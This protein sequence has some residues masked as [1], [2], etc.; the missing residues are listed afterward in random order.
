MCRSRSRR[1]C[2]APSAHWVAWADAQSYPRPVGLC[3]QSHGHRE[4]SMEDAYEPPFTAA[5]HT[6]LVRAVL[7]RPLH[8]I[9]YLNVPRG[10]S[11][12]T[13]Q[14]IDA[15]LQ[16]KSFDSGTKARLQEARTACLR[17][18]EE[19]A[20]D[21]AAYTERGDRLQAALEGKSIPEMIAAVDDLLA[22]EQLDDRSRG[23]L[24]LAKAILEDGAD[25]IYSLDFPV[26][27]LVDDGGPSGP[28]GTQD[29]RS[30][31][32]PS[33]CHCRSH[34]RRNRHLWSRRGRQISRRRA[35]GH[36]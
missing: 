29:R 5:D 9:K 28:G 10:Q 19:Q 12:T 36:L 16:V 13:M 1:S 8:V 17:F 30:R 18:E 3:R 14:L 7:E 31:G 21:S 6:K 23:G 11:P 33:R 24:T 2:S 4:D 34:V 26:W 32:R 27:E 15:A 22:Q 35:S 25:S 20:R